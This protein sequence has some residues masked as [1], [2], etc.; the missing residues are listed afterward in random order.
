M[1]PTEAGGNG[2]DKHTRGATSSGRNADN[3]PKSLKITKKL[4][5][6][7]FPFP[8]KFF[9]KQVFEFCR[10]NYHIFPLCRRL[11]HMDSIP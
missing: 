4:T 10:K 11:F 6:S 5:L 7:C 1:Q 8:C 3:S 9:P 2:L